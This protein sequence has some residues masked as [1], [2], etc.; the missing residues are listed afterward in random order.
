MCEARSIPVILFWNIPSTSML[1]SILICQ[2]GPLQLTR[3][4]NLISAFL[5][6]RL[7]FCLRSQTFC[8]YGTLNLDWIMYIVHVSYPPWASLFS[9][10]LWEICCLSPASKRPPLFPIKPAP[11]GFYPS[12]KSTAAHNFWCIW[13][14]ILL[15]L[16]RYKIFSMSTGSGYL[17]I[18][19][20]PVPVIIIIILKNFACNIL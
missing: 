11:S 15:V 1:P 4:G 5:W 7:P 13:R 12:C 3:H 6:R 2:N 20:P 9:E 14:G 19:Y 10:V 18:Y 8:Y 17:S 16:S